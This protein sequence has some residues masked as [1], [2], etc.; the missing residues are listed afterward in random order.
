MPSVPTNTFTETHT[1]TNTQLKIKMLSKFF[2]IFIK[3]NKTF[4][5]LL[6]KVNNALLIK[7]ENV[8]FF[9]WNLY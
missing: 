9:N 6:F 7:N 1:H 5:T 2:L 8:L 4:K 3:H